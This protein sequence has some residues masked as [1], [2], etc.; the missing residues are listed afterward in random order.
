M[1]LTCPRCGTDVSTEA[2]YCPYCSLP[3]PKRG[4]AAADEK[5]VGSR[6]EPHKPIAAVRIKSTRNGGARPP[7][8][9]ASRTAKP[10]RKQP[11][12][13]TRNRR[14]SV[15]SV[16]ALV[17]LMGVGAYIFV[18]PMVYT[19]QA[20]PK[21]VLAALDKLRKAPSNEPGVTID[22]R[23]SRELETTRRVGNLVAFQ[24]WNVRAIKGTRT[25]VVLAFSYEEVGNVGQSAE[26]LAD[27]SAGTF[28]PQTDLATTVSSR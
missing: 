24:G 18:V 9:A 19:E 13:K 21:T 26:W 6:P 10:P 2:L 4:F 3:K 17:A 23:L 12:K 1:A 5:P 14:A 20:E 28:T 25:R 27:L 22:A 8:P 7:K 11:Q 15:Y 16:A